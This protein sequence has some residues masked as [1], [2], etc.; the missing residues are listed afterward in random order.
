MDSKQEKNKIKVGV[1]RGGTE[2]NFLTSLQQGGDII[3]HISKNLSD[4]YKV[5]DIL[6]D[7]ENVWHLN[8]IPIVPADL[9]RKVDIVWNNGVHSSTTTILN[10]LT[11]RNVG[12]EYFSRVLENNKDM[13]RRH[14]KGIGVEMPRSIVLPLYQKDFD[15]PIEKYAIKKAKEVFEKFSSPWIVKSF[16]EDKNMGIHLAKTFPELIEAI[17]DGVNHNK[18]ILVEE[19]IGGK[20]ASVHSIPKYRG[21]DI[22]VFPLGNSFGIFSNDEKEKLN[23]FVKNLYKHLNINH[24][25]KSDL[26]LDKKGKIHVLNIEVTPD[27]KDSSHFQQVCESVGAKT[28]HIIEH[29]LDRALGPI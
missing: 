22:Y 1:L 10:D 11:I 2:N 12:T 5:F 16:T 8:G 24:Y 17:T 3:S 25:L 29:F 18:S 28:H 9:L 20:V 23:I 14:L 4:K 7:K 27:F 15:G 6:I 26:I 13:L 19:F 21:E